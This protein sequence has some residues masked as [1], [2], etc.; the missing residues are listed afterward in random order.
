[1]KI[2]RKQLVQ[3]HNPV[4]NELYLSSPL[5]VG[6]SRLAF[7]ADVTGLQSLYEEQ[8]QAGVPLLTMADW[9]W[10]STL[11][12]GGRTYTLDDVEMTQYPHQGRTVRYAVE[13]KPGNEEIY[14]WVR[15]NPH[16]YNL[17]R[18]GLLYQGKPIRKEQLSEIHQELDL[19]T[20]IL[21]SRF[22]LEGEEVR[23]S[24]ICHG[25]K[26]VLGFQI[27]S[28]ECAN[29]NLQVVWELPYG[30]HEISG[31]DWNAQERHSTQ[32]LKM[33]SGHLDLLHEMDK[34]RCY[35]S[36]QSESEMS[37][38]QCGKHCFMGKGNQK[39]MVF[40]MALSSKA[41]QGGENCDLET[42]RQE[43][44]RLWQEFWEEGGIISFEGSADVRAQ[45]LERRI[46]LSLYLSVINS[47]TTMPP[48]ETGLTVNSWYGKAHLEMHLWHTAYLPLWGRSKWLKKSLG[49]YHQILPRAKENAAR[50]GYKGARWTKMVGPEGI[51]CPSKVATLLVWQQPHLLYML[52]LLYQA[53]EQE[54]FLQQ[55]WELV[56]QTAEFMADFAVYNAEKQV[57]ELAAPLIPAQ[58]NHK[59][60]DTLN[61]VF[62]V[63][64]WR[65]GLKNAIKWAERLGKEIPAKWQQ[66]ADHMAQPAHLN[67]VYLAHENC[68]DTFTA[69][70]YT[71]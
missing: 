52:E 40:T 18:L 61:P 33:E 14:E 63:E 30:S 66:V 56:E 3:K 35:I 21:H 70:S 22:L 68:P 46:I 38:E 65:W 17:V 47:C 31:A 69:V 2:N 55:H 71:H 67:G 34:D 7:T 23:V 59:P 36:V 1:M 44:I 12:E 27:V 51:D 6:N 16:R 13:K 25:Q 53:G 50:N 11:A 42:C 48:Q 39:E 26:D 32:V 19:Y 58:E 29:G 28:E 37:Y 43:S 20:G 10:H 8:K 41:L 45:E 60:M 24:T 9:G 54:E 64:Y 15:K 4:K 5:T 49:W 62:E 57:Y